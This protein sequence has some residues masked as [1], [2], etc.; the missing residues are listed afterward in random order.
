MSYLKHSS[1]EELEEIINEWLDSMMAIYGDILAEWEENKIVR[2]F[3]GAQVEFKCNNCGKCCEFADH[4][5]WVYPSDMTHWLKRLE[6]D[7]L[8]ALL[9]CILFPVEDNEGAIG[10]GLPSQRMIVEKYQEFI[11]TDRKSVV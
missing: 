3:P 7:D 5:V 2:A 11:K 4:W 6:K 1:D 8:I 10:Y 9:L